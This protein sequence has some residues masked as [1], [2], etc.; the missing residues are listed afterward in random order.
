MKVLVCGGRDYDDKAVVYAMLDR[1][2]VEHPIS[3]VIDG[4]ANGADLLARSWGWDR[5][6][7]RRT[8]PAKWKEH[9]KA[10]G[11]IRN[12]QML[13]EGEPDLVVAFPG[14]R[15]TANMVSLARGSGVKVIEIPA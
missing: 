13:S 1:I 6:V 4:G 8:F 5:D 11:P 7:K 3:L 14:G 15:G 2:H 10:A 9:G 12:A